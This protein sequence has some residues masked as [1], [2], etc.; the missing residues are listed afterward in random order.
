MAGENLNFAVASNELRALSGA[1]LKSLEVQSVSSKL[2]YKGLPG[3]LS[4]NYA[5][6]ESG[7]S[8]GFLY[9]KYEMTSNEE[10]LYWR[11]SKRR[12]HHR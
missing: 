4:E 6:T 12:R 9:Q 3:L 5:L 8:D 11:S 2:T 7:T 10:W 1:L